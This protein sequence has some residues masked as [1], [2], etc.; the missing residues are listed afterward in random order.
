MRQHAVV[1]ARQ[2]RQELE[3]LGGQPDLGRRAGGRA[4]GRSRWSDRRPGRRRSRR[5]PRTSRGAARRECAPAAPPGQTASSRSRRRRDRAHSPCRPRRPAPRARRSAPS[6]PRARAGRPRCLRYPASPRSSTIRSGDALGKHLQRLR[7]RARNVHEIAARPEQRLDRA[8]DGH[9]VVD[10]QDAGFLRHA[11]GEPAGSDLL[12]RRGNHDGELRTAVG[13]VLR[14]DAAALHGQQP[15][16]DREAHARAR[17][18]RRR[19]GAAVEPIE[20]VGQV[21]R[22]DAGTAIASPERPA[23]RRSPARSR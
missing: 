12:R 1:I 9:L 14:P 20:E 13:T 11:A 17:E 22:R 18:V 23:L 2:Q 8:L 19:G 16:R 4:G 3:F 7:A 21:R 10:E 15:A 5:R 6:T